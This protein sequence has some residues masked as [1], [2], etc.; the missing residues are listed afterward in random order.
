MSAVAVTALLERDAFLK[1]LRETLEEAEDGRG[2]LVLLAGEAG[3]GK[4]AL[5]RSFCGELH[6]DVS[7]LGGACDALFT[8]RPLGPLAD[9]AAQIGGPLAELIARDARAYEVLSAV[10]EVL[11]AGPT[12]LIL[13]DLHW[14]DEATLDLLRLL[15][16]RVER[17]RGLVIATYRDDELHPAHPLRLVVGGLAAEE[18]VERMRL[19]PLS[20]AAVRE[21]AAPHAVDAEELFQRTGGNP[22]F[23]TEA[24]ASGV[25]DVPVT[26]RDAVLARAARL[27]RDAHAVIE[28]VAA[29]PPRA[30]LGLL[31]E[32]VGDWIAGLDECLASGM[33]VQEGDGVAF[34]HE[35]ARMAVEESISPFRRL[36]LHRAALRALQERSADFARLAHH[37]EAAGD[38]AAVL[39]F[40]PAAGARASAV[41]AH[42]EAAAQ[43]ARALSFGETL[44]PEERALLLERRGHECYLVDQFDDG[45]ACLEEAIECRRNTG[46]RLREGD[47]L[48]QLSAILRCGARPDDGEVAARRA[49]ALL[50]VEPQSP[51]LA[52]AYSILAMIALNAH[53]TEEALSVAGRAIQLAERFGDTEVLVHSLN[54]IGTTELL[55]GVSGG[56]EKL[57]R[58]LELAWEAG[59]EEHIGRAY[60][61]LVDVAAR[62][63]SYALAEQYMEPGIEYCSERGLDLW[64]R[65]MHVYRARCELDRG[66]WDEAVAIPKS[67]LDAGTPLPRIVGLVVIGLVRARRGDPAQWTALGEAGDLAAASGELQWL[68]PV[69]AARAEAAWLQGDAVSAAAETETAFGL[70]LEKRSP[71]FAG[72]LACWRR[73]CGVREEAPPFVAKPYALQL[74]GDWE[75]AAERWSALRC[76]YDAA[77]ALSDGG[78]EHALRVSLE[79]LQR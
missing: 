72:E 77:L 58:S 48:R 40:A 78:D 23:V 36:E 64:L 57:E 56:L 26:V 47:S 49:V 65:Y 12:V 29:V 35:L 76:P 46:N 11:S 42:R 13:E 16:R 55:A 62:T 38:A 45:V 59:L 15:G 75:R 28:A 14:A 41:G 31:E 32:L 5:V 63:R 4:T 3:V 37:A 24:L 20:L 6:A 51:E 79:T 43:Y 30:E 74:A 68:A 19:P 73:R 67:A 33:L 39:E 1:A 69:A 10:V 2:R 18:G 71:W 27:G 61:H 34:R 9:V 22:F 70:A 8:P 25:P 52:M 21:L 50:E 54:T 66:R 7:V 60:I 17:T 44:S 53:D